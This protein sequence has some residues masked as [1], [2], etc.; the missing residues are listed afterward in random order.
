MHAVHASPRLRLAVI[1]LDF[2]MFNAHREAVIFGSEV[3]GFDERRLLLSDFDFCW[4]A[5]LYDFNSYVGLGGLYSSLATIGNQLPE[6]GRDD[7]ARAMHWLS[8]SRADGFRDGG[9]VFRAR[10]RIGGYRALFGTAQE[11]YYVS[12]IWRPAP[13]RRY[14]FSREG[15]PNT[16]DRFRELV[17]FARKSG[18]DLRLFI[19]PIHGR[20]LLALQE[21]GLWPQY[22]DWKRGLVDVL[23]EEARESGN[24]AFPLW[25]FSGFNSV[26]TEPVPPANDTKSEVLWFWE[27]SH[28]KKE[29]GDLILDRVLGYHSQSRKVPDDFGIPL[30][31]SNLETSLVQSRQAGRK[32]VERED[33]DAQLVRTIVAKALEHS[34]GSNCGFDRQAL[35]EGVRALERGDRNAADAAFARAIAIHE[36]DRRRFVELDVPYRE[37]G[38]EEALQ[39]ASGGS[40]KTTM[41]QPQSQ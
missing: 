3:M 19:A 2:D 10:V 5:L 18:I 17:R 35:S 30:S 22:E 14:C 21:A 1:G 31:K 41:V 36:A 29:T 38:F 20:L 26:T 25:D 28:F 34:T 27:P 8:L 15:Q 33:E 13:A 16:F 39:A 32:Y 4:R 6:R 9:H 24:P 7:P 23:A 11:N 40:A 37:Q 12:S